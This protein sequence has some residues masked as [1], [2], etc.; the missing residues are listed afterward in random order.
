[1]SKKSLSVFTL[2]MMNLAAIGTVKNWPTIAES[3]FSSIFYLLLAAFLFFIPTALVS[4]EL[5]TGW[6]KTGGVFVWVKEAFGH[7]TGF[8]AIWLLWIEGVIWFPTM[9]TFMAATA[10]YFFDPALIE[11]KLYLIATSLTLFWILTWVNLRGMKTSG[12]ISSL[13]VVLGS[14]IPAAVIIFLGFSW[15]FSGH[16]L[17]IP[18]SWDAFFPN[19]S[20]PQQW[21]IFAGV[22]LSLCGM[23]LSAI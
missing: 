23:E 2:A 22:L 6:P 19:F 7:R 5:A 15:Y 13:G 8:L 18:L 10:T 4:A 9:L 17:Q 14:F 1:M 3:G 20:S 11:N 16:S 21:V 12:W